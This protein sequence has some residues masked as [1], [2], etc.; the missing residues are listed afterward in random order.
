M[1]AATASVMPAEQEAVTKPASAPVNS[2]I[3][4]LARR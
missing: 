2:A 3:T 1:Q 4:V